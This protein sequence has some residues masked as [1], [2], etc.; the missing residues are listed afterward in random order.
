MNFDLILQTGDTYDQMTLQLFL[1]LLHDKK[2]DI[3]QSMINS[4]K[5][6]SYEWKCPSLISQIETR[7]PLSSENSVDEQNDELLNHVI[8]NLSDRFI[9]DV[10]SQ[11]DFGFI[12]YSSFTSLTI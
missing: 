11:F 1:D 5:S 2:M 4:I 9:I 3:E 7:Y 12:S 6:L 8:R 10:V